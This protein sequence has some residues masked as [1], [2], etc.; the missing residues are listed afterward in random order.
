VIGAPGWRRFPITRA[1]RAGS[2][3]PRPTTGCSSSTRT[4][5]PAP[6]WSS[7]PPTRATPPAGPA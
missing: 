4:S 1:F 5:R 6:R 7:P 3:A 2:T